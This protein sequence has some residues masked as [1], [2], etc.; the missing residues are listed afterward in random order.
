LQTDGKAI[1]NYASNFPIS[2]QQK[3]GTQ[4][5]ALGTT[6]Y[7]NHNVV[8]AFMVFTATIIRLSR[9]GMVEAKTLMRT[10]VSRL[11][12]FIS[13]PFFGCNC[14]NGLASNRL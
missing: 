8:S 7:G 2:G 9:P 11:F 12:P 4:K 14:K 6:F 13:L 1:F 3:Y 10:K 5:A